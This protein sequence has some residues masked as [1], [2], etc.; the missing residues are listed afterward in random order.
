MRRPTIL[1]LIGGSLLFLLLGLAVTVAI[2]A[3]QEPPPSA[4][5]VRYDDVQ[6]QGRRIYIR[7]GC[8][9]CHTQQV[10]SMEAGVGKV[11]ERGD[12][13]PESVPGDY[14]YQKPVLWGTNRQGPD[15]AHVSSRPYVTRAW[16]VLH[17]KEPR[18]LAP[19]SI[20]PSFAHLNEK[21][22]D[23]LAEYLMTL[24]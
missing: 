17:L 21:E 15:L 1:Y 23:A 13:G 3:I 14:A 22:L 19:G 9:Y 20:M 5:A 2:P 18:R 6:A 11:R 10:R 4:L 24:K 16:H 7:E 12:I 8:G